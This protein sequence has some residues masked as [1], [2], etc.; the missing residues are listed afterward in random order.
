MPV[1]TYPPRSVS[2]AGFQAE[3]LVAF[4]FMAGG[5]EGL[6][7]GLA[8]KLQAKCSERIASNRSRTKRAG[9]EWGWKEVIQ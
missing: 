9:L 3:A 1:V 6:R 2:V 5:I 4:L 8:L 7:S